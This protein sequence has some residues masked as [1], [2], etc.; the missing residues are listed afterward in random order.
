MMLYKIVLVLVV[1]GAISGVIEE[2]GFYPTHLPQS[3][4]TGISE[5]QVTDLSN[6]ASNTPINIFSSFVVLSMVINVLITTFKT[7]ITVIPLLTAYGVPLGLAVAIQ[8]IIWLVMAWGIYE[9]W[10]G[11]TPPAMD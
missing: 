9:M 5:A 3:G 2:S 10:T 6:A 8:T 7:V 11:H 4:H 1:F